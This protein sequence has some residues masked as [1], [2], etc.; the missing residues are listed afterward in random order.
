MKGIS[1]ICLRTVSCVAFLLSAFVATAENPAATPKKFVLFGFE[2]NRTIPGK[3]VPAAVFRETAPRFRDAG[4]DGVGL[5]LMKRET[6]DG[7]KLRY[8]MNDDFA[9][10]YEDFAEDIPVYRKAFE[11]NGLKYNFLKTFFHAPTKHIA[12]DDDA[13]WARVT[14]TMRALARVAKD[15]GFK[16]LCVDHEDYHRSSQFARRPS[17]PPFDALVPM[18]RTR[19]RQ[20]FTAVF[21]E[22]PDA[23]LFFY[24]FL[25]W[26]DRLF[27]CRDTEGALRDAGELWP[28]FAN[29]ILDA[30]PPDGKIVDA[31]EWAYYH[32]EKAYFARSYNF[33]RTAVLGMVAPENRDKYRL[34]TSMG[35]GLYTDMYLVPTNSAFYRAPADGSRMKKFAGLIAAAA[36][37]ADE[38]VWFWNE[39]VQ[40]VKWTTSAKRYAYADTCLEDFLPGLRAVCDAAR[41]ADGF[42]SRR[43]RELAVKGLLTNLVGSAAWKYP[44]GM[45]ASGLH[46][47]Y[48][49]ENVPKPWYFWRPGAV[50]NGVAGVHVGGG[51]DKGATAL[52]ARGMK[53]GSFTYT[54]KNASPGDYYVIKGAAKGPASVNITPHSSKG[55]IKWWDEMGKIYVA[56]F[57]RPDADGWK[58]TETILRIPDGVDSMRVNFG[59][60]HNSDDE[61]T[62]FDELTV[63]RVI[64]FTPDNPDPS[65][66]L[67]GKNGN[68]R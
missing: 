38:Y 15:A 18:V 47:S 2:F 46:L 6:P 64:W 36:D 30:L 7:R 10:R 27:T 44:K 52:V 29:G 60:R 1:V 21:E 59:W 42:V 28:A 9:W 41:S 66:R 16:G 54:I 61:E 23:E 40:W 45:P 12:W 22:F 31:D 19:A 50:S 67:K 35:F 34:Q 13:A 43:E 37:A 48:K 17:E 55:K 63:E 20:V 51:V 62:R 58:R 8:P 3:G 53:H 39:K 57:G 65:A 32:E 25:G 11:E 33:R 4:I 56:P 14:D 68:V 24:W 5:Y 26:R 49:G